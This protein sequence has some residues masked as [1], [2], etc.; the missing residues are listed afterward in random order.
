MKLDYIQ[1]LGANALWLMPI[2]QSPS[3][4]C[5]DVVDYYQIQEDYGSMEDFD[6]LMEEC[7]KRGIRII[8][9]LVLNHTSSQ[10]PWFLK[11]L[12]NDSSL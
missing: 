3:N 5:Y 6:S 2:F 9:D 7:K 11:S 10:H 4:H 12:E 8:L 1:E